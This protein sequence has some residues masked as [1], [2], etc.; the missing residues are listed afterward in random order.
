MNFICPKPNV[1]HQLHMKLRDY[2]ESVLLKEV[3][4]P[5]VALVLSGWTM[6]NDIDK[7]DRWISTIEW[8]HKHGCSRLIEGI[9]ETDKYYV[10]EISDWRPF[11]YSSWDETIKEKPTSDEAD[12]HFSAVKEGWPTILDASFSDNTQPIGFSGK[13]LRRLVVKYN[14]EYLPPWGSWSDHLA[15]GSPSKFTELRKK[16]NEIISPH[17]VDHIDFIKIKSIKV[18]MK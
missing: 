12:K 16:V 6:S 2:W 13:K 18:S 11:E 9:A 10:S 14:E 4:Q 17:V 8:A 7:K 3:E 5:P 1:W 15:N